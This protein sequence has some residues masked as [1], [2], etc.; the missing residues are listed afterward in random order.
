MNRVVC[1]TGSSSGIGAAIALRLAREGFDLALHCRQNLTGLF[2]TAA[3]IR[4]LAPQCRLRCFTADLSD[5]LACND[6]VGAVFHWGGHVTAWINNAGADILTNGAWEADFD[7]KMQALWQVD[8]AA[9][10]RLSRLVAQRLLDS[11][12]TT[13]AEPGHD[14][15][16]KSRLEQPPIVAPSS[17][18]EHQ[19]NDS[20]AYQSPSPP[21][22]APADPSPSPPAHPSSDQRQVCPAATGDRPQPNSPTPSII[23]MGWDQA[24]YGMEGEAGQLFGTAKAAVEGFTKALSQTVGHRIRVNLIAP[25]WI[26]TAW[27]GRAEGTYWD[28][29]AC[30]ESLAGRWGTPEEVAEVVAWL[31]TDQASFVNGQRIEINGGR[32]WYPA[33]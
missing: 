15:P 20:S 16:T 23:N 10:V 12:L 19:L 24:A 17:L 11:P 26:K 27:G 2:H 29:R 8:V 3:R 9:T 25:G 32:R 22:P 30:S 6:L 18:P 4:K 5:P 7:T 1:V 31:I 14:A 33:D 28:Q 21:T 13:P